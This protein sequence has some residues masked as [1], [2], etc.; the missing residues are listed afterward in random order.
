M[1]AI[2]ASPTLVHL[3]CQADSHSAYLR[4]DA[5]AL[6]FLADSFDLVVYY[7]S[8]MDVDDMDGSVR[9]AAR[10]LRHGGKLC[11]CVTHPISDA[12]TFVSDEPDSPFVIEGSYLGERRWVDIEMAR[13]GLHMQFQGWA[14]SLEAYFSALENAGFTVQTVR[15]P[16]LSDETVARFPG[17][18]RWQRIPMFL[19]WSAVKP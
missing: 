10:V 7:N 3:A 17:E 2:D 12:G 6:P 11:A 4:S 13:D 14:Y 16:R 19:M 8:L 1:T 18:S 9:E 5:A 15:E